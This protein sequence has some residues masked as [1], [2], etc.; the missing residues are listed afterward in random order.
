VLAYQ[1]LTDGY[2]EQAVD[3]FKVVEKLQPKD[4]IASQ[5]VKQLQKVPDSGATGSADGTVAATDAVPSP[6]V[7]A[8]TASAAPPLKQ[9]TLDGGWTAQANGGTTITVNYADG[10]TFSW[11]VS[12]QG[13]D[14]TI[15]GK[16]SYVNGILTMVQDQASTMVG[17]VNF[18][19]DTHFTFKVLGGGPEDP[20]LTFTKAQ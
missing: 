14:R 17:E 1:Y 18:T 6:P 13:K 20:G 10:K 5:M 4:Q 16:Y 11:K 9:G 2:A 15:A 8:A 7:D 3:Q 19:D 12:Q